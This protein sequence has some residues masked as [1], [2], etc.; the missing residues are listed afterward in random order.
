MPYVAGGSGLPSEMSRIVGARNVFDDVDE[1]WPEVSWEEVA[2]RD[3]DIIVIG[4]LSERGRPGDSAAEKRA[5]L[6]RHPVI[7]RLA[8][9]RNDRIIEVPGIE[10]DPSVRSV[11]ALRLLADG[12]RESGHGR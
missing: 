1:D 8:A 11:H 6:A 2:E 5:T 10:L 4:D 7:S 3:P 12:M 9:V